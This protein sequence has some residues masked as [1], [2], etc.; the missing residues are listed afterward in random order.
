[1]QA[2]QSPVIPVV[3]E[4]IRQ[5]PGTISL[6]QGVVG[7]GPPQEA[8]DAINL[9][10]SDP[11]NH[12]YKPVTGLAALVEALSDKLQVENGFGLMAAMRSS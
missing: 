4:L 1:M 10:A 8:F 5:T 2:V 7:Y 3:A 6:G 11:Q 12:K 9:F